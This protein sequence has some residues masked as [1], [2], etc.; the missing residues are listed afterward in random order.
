VGSYSLGD[1]G[2]LSTHRAPK[3][4]ANPPLEDR[5]EEDA[6]GLGGESRGWRWA[7]CSGVSIEH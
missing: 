2:P 1:A 7:K 3:Q 4:R 6:G 5:A